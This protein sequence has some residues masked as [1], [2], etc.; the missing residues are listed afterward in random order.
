[1]QHAAGAIHCCRAACACHQ[2]LLLLLLV[3]A[4]LALVG[5]SAR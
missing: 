5:S 2:L 3:E 1:M 4:V